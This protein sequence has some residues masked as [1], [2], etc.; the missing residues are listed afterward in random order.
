MIRSFEL[1]SLVLKPGSHGVHC[2]ISPL[3]SYKAAFALNYV[4]HGALRSETRR[5]NGS[6]VSILVQQFFCVDLF[7]C[8]AVFRVAH[9]GHIDSP[10]VL[11]VDKDVRVDVLDAGIVDLNI[12]AEEGTEEG[13]QLVSGDEV[14]QG[15]ALVHEDEEGSEEVNHNDVHDGVFV[16][17]LHDSG[18]N[19][20]KLT[21][22]FGDECFGLSVVEE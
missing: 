20:A 1:G 14:V 4:T 16:Q 10:V 6:F 11:I 12:N 15:F 21:K 3:A 19:R 9:V 2:V 18:L 17:G 22:E 7:R 5:R 13:Q 8:L